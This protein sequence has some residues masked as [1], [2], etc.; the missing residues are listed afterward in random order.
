MQLQQ[1][2][3]ELQQGNVVAI[4]TETVYGLA[5]DATNPQAIAKIFALKQRPNDNPLI[6]HVGSTSEVVN[7]AYIQNPIEQKI[8][9]TLMPGPITILLQRKNNIPD[10][11]TA[12]SELVAIRIPQHPVALEILQ[13]SWLALAAPSANISGKPSPT[14]VDMVQ[15]NF[16]DSIG[17]VDGGDCAVWIESTVVQVQWNTVL[18]HRPWFIT[19]EDIYSVVWPNIEVE[20]SHAKTNISPGIKYKHYAPK[21]HIHLIEP[22][23]PL[24]NNSPNIG[25]L[26][27]DERLTINQCDI[28]Q[29]S[30]RIYRWGSDTNLL[31]CA[32]K[33][34]QLY[35]QADKDDIRDLYVEHLP[36]ENGIGYAIMNR[37]RKS[38]E[39]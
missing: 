10:V 16:G 30:Y 5:A 6:V 37:V 28:E 25:L 21:A 15:Q 8:I 4:P 14:T 17:I 7:Y 23:A 2:I 1:A 26:V 12:G 34:Y 29:C 27:T 24:P 13:S 33:L 19:P 35:H 31:E 18:I 3:K 32:Q 38:L 9:D 36:E 22:G 11:V 39:Q 20:Y